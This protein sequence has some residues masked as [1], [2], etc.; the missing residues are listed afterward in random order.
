M[1]VVPDDVAAIGRYIYGAAEDIGPP[2]SH[3]GV[4]QRL[5]IRIPQRGRNVS[6][7]TH[8]NSTATY[9]EAVS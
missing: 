7:S 9:Q 6:T 3:L 8:G 4:P 1:T 2:P 5:S